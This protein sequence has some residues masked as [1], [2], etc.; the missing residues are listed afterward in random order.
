MRKP[1]IGDKLYLVNAGINVRGTA[2]LPETCEV[3]KVGRKYFTV[4]TGDY[5]F[6]KIFTIDGFSEKSEYTSNWRLYLSKEDYENHIESVKWYKKFNDV[7]GG[8][9]SEKFSLSQFKMAA[10][11][12]DIT[13]DG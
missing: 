8:Y 3:V 5:F 1:E 2:A 11:I 12:F 13:I 6:D 4:S 9:S 10:E 7:F